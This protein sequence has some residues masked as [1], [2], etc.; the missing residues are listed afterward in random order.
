M[1]D[2][3]ASKS[4]TRCTFRLEHEDGREWGNAELRGLIRAEREHDGEWPYDAKL[5]AK[6]VSDYGGVFLLDTCHGWHWLD[7]DVVV[8]W[9]LAEPTSD[10][11]E[12]A[13]EPVIH[14]GLRK[15]KTLRERV[16]PVELAFHSRGRWI[17]EVRA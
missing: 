16:N 12:P 14:I 11:P 5:I 6:A 8:V 4:M 9:E 13:P 2:M 3:I 17:E 10:W 1:S 7:D 15:P